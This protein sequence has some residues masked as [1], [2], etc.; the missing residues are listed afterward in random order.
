MV[1][2]WQTLKLLVTKVIP[3]LLK[4][5]FVA[6]LQTLK[7]LIVKVI[8]GLI[9]FALKSLLFVFIKLPLMILK[10][11]GKI[12]LGLAKGLW[13]VISF[14]PKMLVKLFSPK[15]LLKGIR[16]LGKLVKSLGKA[17]LWLVKLPFKLLAKLGSSIKDGISKL[18][19]F[20]K[21]GFTQMTDKFLGFLKR[22]NPLGKDA[23]LKL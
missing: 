5:V 15:N 10:L 20:I 2:L 16:G 17:L 22:I 19:S 9:K 12:L 4:L 6:L 14:V 8:P 3:G 7:F 23:M 1:A 11:T 21:T 13:K 18:W